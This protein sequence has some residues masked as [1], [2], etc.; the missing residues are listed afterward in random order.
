MWSAVHGSLNMVQ[1]LVDH[2][3]NLQLTD[4]EGRTAMD[5][6]REMLRQR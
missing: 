5:V 3:S 4:P 2:G 6:A 1:V